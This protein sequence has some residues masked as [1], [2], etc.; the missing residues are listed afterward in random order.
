MSSTYKLDVTVVELREAKRIARLSS[1]E[2][3][4]LEAVYESFIKKINQHLKS[5]KPG[6][7]PKT[8]QYVFPSEIVKK[9][10]FN[11]IQ[12]NTGYD[13]VEELSKRLKQQE[14]SEERL[15]SLLNVVIEQDNIK[16]RNHPWLMNEEAILRLVE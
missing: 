10:L 16:A 7:E 3:D 8:Y 12:N 4:S 11:E 6:Q 1:L 2:S 15:R 9:M 5:E 14:A 13:T